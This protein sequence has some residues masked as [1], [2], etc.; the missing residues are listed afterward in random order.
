MGRLRL[1]KQ[2]VVPEKCQ[3][4]LQCNMLNPVSAEVLTPIL[5]A[6]STEF[7]TVVLKTLESQESRLRVGNRLAYTEVPLL[8]KSPEKS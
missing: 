4:P 7:S 5:S 6:F 2:E 8:S 1:L 3:H